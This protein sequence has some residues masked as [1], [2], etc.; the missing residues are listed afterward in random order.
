MSGYFVMLHTKNYQNRPMFHGV[1]QKIKVAPV[2]LRHGV[3]QSVR[4][5]RMH[6]SFAWKLL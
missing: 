5:C 4:L 3:L 2:F 1:I 6:R